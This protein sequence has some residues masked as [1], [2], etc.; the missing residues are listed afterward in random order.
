MENL[1]ALY[2][3]LLVAIQQRLKE[4]V[5]E[6]RYIAEDLGQLEFYDPD[7]GERPPV[8]W[9]CALIDFTNATYDDMGGGEGMQWATDSIQIRIGFDP[10][11][12]ANNLVTTEVSGKAL[13]YY[14][15]EMA[16]HQALHGWDGGGLCQSMSRRT[17]ITEK[18][19]DPYRVR[20]VSFSTSFMDDSAIPAKSQVSRPPLD[21][22]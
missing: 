20:V 6:L 4:K 2:S 8:S 12:T 19:N 17:A 15:L 1:T 5:P 14:E 16:I 3:Q 22:E 18:R 21:F 9:P 11:S 7:A 13:R 10:Y